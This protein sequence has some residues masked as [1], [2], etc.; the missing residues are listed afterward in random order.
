[1]KL[2]IKFTKL[3]RIA[4]ISHLDLTRA[5]LRALRVSG[6]KPAYS[7]GFNPHPKMSIICPLPLGFESENEL[8]EVEIEK[9]DGV[10][11]INF[12]ESTKKLNKS[13]PEGIRILEIR[14][15]GPN[16]PKSL[17]SHLRWI[18][19]EITSDAVP[20]N[21]PEID[22][23]LQNNII[24]NKVN[25]KTGIEKEIDIRPMIDCFE[26]IK[27]LPN[28][29]IYRCLVS[30]EPGNTLNPS[31]LMQAWFDYNKAGFDP[32]RIRI[33]RKSFIFE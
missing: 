17:A 25:R 2:I 10:A 28:L 27:K 32:A 5:F 8:V 1:M 3:G 14:E 15:K 30:A 33:L 26:I 16:E 19:Y 21:L 9:C 12:L 20:K 7:K 29:Y 13:L 4:Y 23:W 6:L 22:L 24:V 18:E 31:T 11:S